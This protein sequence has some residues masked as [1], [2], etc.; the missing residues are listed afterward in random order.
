MLA[1]GVALAAV[2]SRSDWLRNTLSGVP[3]LLI[4]IPAFWLGIVLIQVLSF[5]LAWVPVIGGEDWQKL[6]LPVITLAIPVSA[7]LAQI[8][9]RT[10]DDVETSPFVHVV[11]SKGASRWWTL[12]R[13]TARNSLLPVLTISGLIFAELISGSVVVETVFARNGIG[14]LTNQARHRAGHARHAGDRRHRRG[15]IRPDQPRRGS[16]LPGAGS[17]ASRAHER[18]DRADSHARERSSRS[19]RR[20]MTIATERSLLPDTIQAV[21]DVFVAELPAVEPSAPASAPK[22]SSSCGPRMARHPSLARHAGR[23][24]GRRGHR[25]ALGPR[26]RS[27]RA[28]RRVHQ[29]RRPAFRRRAPQHLFGTDSVGR[30]QFSRVIYGSSESLS[31]ALVA[32]TVGMVLGTVLG[33]VSGSSGGIADDAI[34]RFVDVLL[35]IPGLLLALTIVILLGPGTINVAIA[36]GIGSVAT[37]ARLVR[38]EVVQVRGT[39]YVEAAFG[40][41]ARFVTVLWRHILPNSTRPVVAL[42]AMQ[43]GIAILALSTLGF[44][45]YGVTPPDPEWG[46]IIAQGRDMLGA[47]WWVTTLPG[48]VIVL[49][50]LSANRISHAL[51]SAK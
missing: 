15:R 47:A 48:A 28:L 9:L 16:A 44:L 7:P 1:V 20:I 12:S 17:A 30:D 14:R 32:V 5:Q 21:E 25:G 40:S 29:R 26:A 36:V 2:Y 43:F 6:I 33:V 42:A 31:A 49:V 23:L 38:S 24:V 27:L 4:S 41:G 22:R 10:L 13:H 37:F 51:G 50:V 46:M 39:E 19:L 34:M 3:S 8:I 45:G 35:S 18:A 11:E